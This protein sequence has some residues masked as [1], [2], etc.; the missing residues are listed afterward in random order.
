MKQPKAVIIIGSVRSGT[1]MLR[2]I[3]VKIPNHGTWDCDEINP[4]WRHGN[5]NHPHDELSKEMATP[6]IVAFIRN[7]FRKIAKSLKVNTVVEK[8][9]ANSLRLAYVNKIFPDAK[10]IFIYRDGRDVAASAQLRWNAKFDFNYS[11][12]KFRYVPLVDMPYI[13]FYYIS[14]RIKGIFSS[15][16]KLKSWGPRYENMDEDVKKYSILEVCALQWKHYV[17]NT[18][19]DLPQVESNNLLTLKYETLVN[20][21]EEEMIKVCKFLDLPSET[22]QQHQLTKGISN[23][24]VGNWKKLDKKQIDLIEKHIDPLLSKLNYK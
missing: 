16:Q 15:E 23:R 13:L 3:L 2:D 7:E 11:L 18:L 9:T 8:S 19:E 12:K 10:Y 6:R 1:N 5:L 21:P 14:N 17:E 22:V 20:N 4:I 24:S